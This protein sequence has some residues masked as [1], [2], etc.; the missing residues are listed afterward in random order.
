MVH[1]QAKSQ[2]SHREHD[3]AEAPVSVTQVTAPPLPRASGRREDERPAP[4]LR[5]RGAQP[6]KLCAPTRWPCTHARL[7]ERERSVE[8]RRAS[9]FPPGLL[10]GA[11]AGLLHSSCSS[12][13]E[14]DPRV[15]PR[16]VVS[17]RVRLLS[18]ARVTH[19]TRQLEKILMLGCL[20]ID[21]YYFITA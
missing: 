20:G 16:L 8:R 10:R 3:P 2:T 7:G 21:K 12:F 6:G 19:V 9:P 13:Q 5:P 18:E 1:S 17:V 4:C 11:V 14:L 15:L